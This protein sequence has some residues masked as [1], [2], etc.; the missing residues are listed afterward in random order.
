MHSTRFVVSLWIAFTIAIL[1][2]ALIDLSINPW[3]Y[4]EHAFSMQP[5][6]S[7]IGDL[8]HWGGRLMK[9]NAVTLLVANAIV[10]GGLFALPVSALVALVRNAMSPPPEVEAPRPSLPPT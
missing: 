5:D 3:L 2:Y 10:L 4:D 6:L 9:E 8:V 1:G 7:K